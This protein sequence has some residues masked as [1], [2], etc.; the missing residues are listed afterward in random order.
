MIMTVGHST[1]PAEEFLALLQ[2]HG[3]E[4]VADVRTVPRSRRHPHFSR[5]SLA[6][7]LP[8]HRIAY[9]HFP[10]LGGLRKP[11]P[12]STNAAWRVEGF[13]GY[14]DH[15]QTPEFASGLEALLAFGRDIRVAV[16]CA[17]AKWWQCHR[18]LIADALV[19]RGVEVRH[20]LSRGD[21]PP[22]ELTPFARVEGTS[23]LYPALI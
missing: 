19:A 18:Q 10:A 2:A 12:G 17:E 22:H 9:E 23:V 21:A 3:V 13:R 6:A 14:A 7:F 15:M 8:A 4:G 16:M 5:E 1:R 20:I 11:R